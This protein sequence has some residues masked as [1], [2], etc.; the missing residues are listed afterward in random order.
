MPNSFLK[1]VCWFVPPQSRVCWVSLGLV[2]TT[3]L[4]CFAV[5][6]TAVVEECL[7]SAGRMLV[8]WHPLAMLGT[9]SKCQCQSPVLGGTAWSGSVCSYMWVV[10]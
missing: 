1:S 5:A 8:D 9:L 3:E 2:L 10:F 4:F 6:G 7:V